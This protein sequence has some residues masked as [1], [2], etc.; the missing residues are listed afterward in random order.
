[1]LINM[2]NATEIKK[3]FCINSFRFGGILLQ[4]DSPII[5]PYCCSDG[6]YEFPAKI[7]RVVCVLSSRENIFP[8]KYLP[9][10]KC[11]G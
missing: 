5:S 1:M 9:C 8:R 3:N 7:V 6:F 4:I 11:V 10:R 2:T